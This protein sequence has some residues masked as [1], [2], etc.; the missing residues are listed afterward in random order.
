MQRADRP[1]QLPEQE[2]VVPRSR[3]KDRQQADGLGVSEDDEPHARGRAQ[4]AAARTGG[5]LVRGAGAAGAGGRLQRGARVG[6]LVA[7][8][9]GE[10]GRRSDGRRAAEADVHARHAAAVHRVAAARRDGSSPLQKAPAAVRARGARGGDGVHAR[11][12]KAPARAEERGP[13]ADRR[14]GGAHSE[15]R[16]ASAFCDATRRSSASTSSTRASSPRRSASRQ[17]RPFSA[18]TDACSSCPSRRAAPVCIWCPA[19]RPW[20]SALPRPLRRRRSCS[21]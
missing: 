17:R 5:H 15:L 11:A 16:I 19:P 13:R 8:P 10:P 9:S 6:A 2:L 12:G 7:H 4:P 3:W 14:R 18:P 20:C 21:A 1:Y